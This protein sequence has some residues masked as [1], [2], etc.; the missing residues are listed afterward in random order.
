M[1]KVMDV[2]DFILKNRID[3]GRP[4]TNLELQKYL[5]FVNAKFLCESG[6]PLFEE[7]IEKWKFGPVVSEVYHEYKNN[8]GNKIME[9]SEHE[10]INFNEDGIKIEN[11]CFDEKSIPDEIKNSIR[12]SIENLSNYTSYELV[13]ET[14]KHNEWKNDE[15]R[16]LRG[17]PHLVYNQEALK[18]YFKEHEEARIW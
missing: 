12:D 6:K 18:N 15:E 8:K 13:E 17:V 5:Y 3:S 2:A 10:T 16:I 7:P 11:N 9:L 4:I 1:L 14:H